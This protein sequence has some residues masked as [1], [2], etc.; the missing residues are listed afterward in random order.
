MMKLITRLK[1]KRL[2]IFQGYNKICKFN[3]VQK[4]VDRLPL[5]TYTLPVPEPLPS[6]IKPPITMSIFRIATLTLLVFLSVVTFGQESENSVDTKQTNVTKEQNNPSHIRTPVQ[7]GEQIN[8][9]K[10]GA[11]LVRLQTKNKSISALRKNGNDKLADKIETEQKSRNMEIVSAFKAGFNFCPVYFFFSDDSQNIRERQFDKVVFL[12]KSLLPDTT[13][14][15]TKDHFL[16]AE[17]GTT[18]GDT[19]FG[20]LI[21]K[22]DQLIQLKRPFPY[23]V[24]TFGSLPIKRSAYKTVK[25]MNKKLHQFYGS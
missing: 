7:A 9:L 6:I 11:L 5:K 13:I 23:Y 14:K 22:S 20:A 15:F 17:F 3:K 21:I 12:S 10:N 8:Q 2:W 1:L 18:D 24:R 4:Y 25:K 16:T 19:S